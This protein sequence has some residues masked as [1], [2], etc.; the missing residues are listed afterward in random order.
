MFWLCLEDD[1]RL[2]RDFLQRLLYAHVE[3]PQAVGVSGIITNY[4]RPRWFIFL[5]GPFH[6]ERQAAY[7]RAD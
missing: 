3:H 2:E 5:R 6:E 7:W 1:V 4:R